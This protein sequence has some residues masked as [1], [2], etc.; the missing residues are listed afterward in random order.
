LRFFVLIAFLLLIPFISFSQNI[1]IQGKITDSQ[2][3]VGLIGATIFVTETKTGTMADE[4]GNYSISLSPGIYIFRISYVGY[5]TLETEVNT[6]SSR[7]DFELKS[8]IRLKEIIVSSRRKE[9]NLLSL[10]MGVERLNIQEIKTMPALMGEVDILKAIQ[11]LPGVQT[12]SEGGSGFSV[13]GGSPDQN[14]IVLDNTTV[15]NP[16]H[17]MGFFSIFN[18]DIISGIELYK[19]D[20]PFRFGGRLSSLLEVNTKSEIPSRFGGTGGIGLISSRLML[21]GP[22]GEKTSYMVGGRRSYA[23]LFLKLSSDENIR[24][25]HIYFYDTNLKLSHR[26]SD[27]DK[28]D[29]NFYYGLDDFGAQPG[30]F[31]YGNLASS[32]I[33]NRVFSEDLFGKFSLNFSDYNYSLGNKLEGA[34][35]KWTSRITDWAL[36]ADFYHILSKSSELNYGLASIFHDFQPGK[37]VMSNLPEY[38]VPGSKAL[39]HSAYLS[40]KQTLSEKWSLKYGA[41]LTLFQNIDPVHHNYFVAE[42]GISTVYRVNEVSSFKAS[43]NHNTQ[44]MQLA[45]NSASGSP[46]D[47]WFTAGPNIKPQKVIMYSVGY[48]RNFNDNMF[49]TSVELY[50]KDLKNVIDFAEHARLILNENLE[51]EVRAGKGKAYG[52]ELMA[53]KNSGR[54][55]GFVNYTLSRSERTIAEI[56]EGKTY[57]APYDKTHSLNVLASYEINKKVN[58]SATWVFASGTP[59]TY[60]TG[61]FALGEEYFPIYSGRNEYRKPNYHRLDLSLNYIPNPDSKKFWKSEWNFSLYNAYNK[62]NPWII[63]YDQDDISGMPYAEMLYL[64]GVIPSITYNFKF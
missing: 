22:I 24:S 63:Y 8:D 13:R 40:N 44:F 3:N 59:T 37:V 29:F 51:S 6:Q 23:D 58:V 57:L 11:L 33:W 60:P 5:E 38:N 41:R 34:Q 30:A 14:L 10:T 12:A 55:T 4:S 1:L 39:E 21:E 49:E 47:I 46:L 43:Y 35:M 50:Y 7:W 64:F 26:L 28:L 32:L 61:R 2:S 31:K 53:K 52:I 25:A 42:P 62:K 36:R 45:N 16:S 48:F 56:N 9:E 27:S 15:Y 17:L 18:N 20:I 19:G 54:L